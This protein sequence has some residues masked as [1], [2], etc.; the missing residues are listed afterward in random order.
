MARFALFLLLSAMLLRPA[1]ADDSGC[2]MNA[3]SDLMECLGTYASVP[4][5]ASATDTA[6]QATYYCSIYTQLANCWAQGTDCLEWRPMQIEADKFCAIANSSSA[7]S[8][9]GSASSGGTVSDS[10]LA[11]STATAT[12]SG[13]LSSV[14]AEASNVVTSIWNDDSGTDIP[15]V[16][17]DLGTKTEPK[18]TM[19]A[20]SSGGSSTR[21]AATGSSPSSTSGSISISVGAGGV[22]VNGG[23]F[24]ALGALASFVMLVG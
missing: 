11:T 23:T 17:N 15:V 10:A 21:G 1:Q 5:V 4:P 9:T 8:S 6:S 24:F 13:P 20:T 2:N 19:P 7:A 18:W 22:A 3:G 16:T 14:V 12:T